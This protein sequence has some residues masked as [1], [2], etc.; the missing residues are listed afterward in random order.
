MIYK[1][2]R[3]EW[4]FKV[5]MWYDNH[6]VKSYLNKICKLA[7]LDVKNIS[8]LIVGKCSCNFVFVKDESYSQYM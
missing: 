8:D 6:F 4:M 5:V 3:M 2:V 1:P 7:L